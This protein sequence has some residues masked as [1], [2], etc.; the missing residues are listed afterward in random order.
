MEV[1]LF[2]V[3]GA[4]LG[5]LLTIIFN[6]FPSCKK[7]SWRNPL[8][9]IV[10]VLAIVLFYL[11]FYKSPFIIYTN[12]P[13]EE[14]ECVFE[15]PTELIGKWQV[16][17][18]IK[19][20]SEEAKI[21]YLSYNGEKIPIVYR[22][23]EGSFVKERI[24]ERKLDIGD[25]GPFWV[26]TNMLYGVNKYT[27]KFEIEPIDKK[28]KGKKM[29]IKLIRQPWSHFSRVID[30]NWV[31]SGQEFKVEV[32]TTNYGTTSNFYVTWEIYKIDTSI[33]GR[34]PWNY[35]GGKAFIDIG[36][37]IKGETKSTYLENIEDKSFKIN[38]PGLYY[39]KTYVFKNLLPYL[40]FKEENL[41]ETKRR[42]KNIWGIELWEASDPHQMILLYVVPSKIDE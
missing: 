2:L 17:I 32:Q 30:S 23:E 34:A 25:N 31:M 11:N 10:G 36:Q 26:D 35:W 7:L 14:D 42:L 5:Y 22:D 39:I 12:T 38:E 8:I 9:W 24:S 3:G 29:E 18:Y 16:P 19:N 20:K 27:F 28:T 33:K 41:G 13:L 6:N 37:I 21:A 40:N 1:I 4:I 15:I